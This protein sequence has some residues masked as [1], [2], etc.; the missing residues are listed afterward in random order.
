MPVVGTLLRLWLLVVLGL[1]LESVLL[2]L[3][4]G[5]LVDRS[6]WSRS[7]ANVVLVV[8]LGSWVVLN[9]GWTWRVGWSRWLAVVAIVLVVDA[10][11]FAILTV[12]FLV[13]AQRRVVSVGQRWWRNVD[14]ST[15]VEE[16]A[17]R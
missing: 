13:R 12:I 6:R 4:L 11:I 2:L 3:L 14:V 17:F 5:L 1:R 10:G 8:L 9:R 15:C 16:F 7:L